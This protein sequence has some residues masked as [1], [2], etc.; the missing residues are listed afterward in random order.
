MALDY[1]KKTSVDAERLSEEF[2]AFQNEEAEICPSDIVKE[3]INDFYGYDP[4]SKYSEMYPDD[5][6]R[7]MQEKSS[8]ELKYDEERL[9][10]ESVL[11]CWIIDNPKKAKIW[12]TLFLNS[13]TD[14][15]AQDV[16][17]FIKILGTDDIKE[18]NLLSDKY[19]NSFIRGA[20]VS[21]YHRCHDGVYYHWKRWIEEYEEYQEFKSK[22]PE[23]W[24]KF[25]WSI[26]AEDVMTAIG[27]EGYGCK[28]DKIADGNYCCDLGTYH[29]N[30]ILNK[31]ISDNQSLW[32]EILLNYKAEEKDE[33]TYLIQAWLDNFEKDNDF[34]VWKIKNPELWRERKQWDDYR[35]SQEMTNLNMHYIENSLFSLFW[36]KE[37]KNSWD[38]WK[39][40]NKKYWE[41]CFEMHKILR[42][43]IYVESKWLTHLCRNS[44]LCP[45]P[46]PR[47]GDN[48]IEMHKLF[49][50]KH[51]K[52]LNE[53]SEKK[54]F[55]DTHC[56]EKEMNFYYEQ[57]RLYNEESPQ[58]YAD[59]KLGEYW[60]ETHKRQWRLWKHKFVWKKYYGNQVHYK[61]CDYFEVWKR[62]HKRK[63]NLWVE[64]EF[65]TYKEMV[66]SVDIWYSWL[67]DKDNAAYFENWAINNIE[68]W[69]GKKDFV[70]HF[71]RS[72]MCDS[73]GIMIKDYYGWRNEKTK[74]WD[75]WKDIIEEGLC[76]ELFKKTDISRA[77]VPEF[78]LKLKIEELKYLALCG[79]AIFH[80]HL[81]IIEHNEK[82]GYINE[83]GNIVIDIQYDRV[84]DFKRGIAAVKIEKYVAEE[85]IKETGDWYEIKYGGKWGI[86]DING[87]YLRYP[88]YDYLEFANDDII[89]FG[90]EGKLDL[91]KRYFIG[92]KW[93]LMNYEM[94]IIIPAKYSYLTLF[95]NGLIRA[96][97]EDESNCPKWGLMTT[98]GKVISPFK[99]SYIYDSSSIY[100]LANI[101]SI[102]KEIN[103][104]DYPQWD[105]FGGEWGYIDNTGNE[106]APFEPAYN[107]ADFRIQH[108]M[109]IGNEENEYDDDDY[110]DYDDYDDDYDD[111]C[112]ATS[113]DSRSFS[114]YS[115]S[116]AQDEMGYSDDDIDDIFDGDPNAY[117]NI[118]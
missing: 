97:V 4:Y 102:Y 110:D 49:I 75:Y 8:E 9:E 96:K 39:R 33:D 54:H 89:L 98:D 84:T 3:D 71:E 83:E 55:V 51:Y 67:S 7:M 108:P 50:E 94:E 81:A 21:P 118:D 31:W 58:M 86:I 22:A 93:G 74:E 48:E 73:F 105:Y 91:D 66:K 76:I 64:K 26:N 52:G 62:I 57:R 14:T 106:V 37:N 40:K 41:E 19:C 20:I 78:E 56:S 42:W 112:T 100:M 111:Y 116:Y 117:W 6:K 29:A 47:L 10:N 23:E 12:Y 24:Q 90:K 11:K 46:R 92:S 60:I 82:F 34:E 109:I 103:E 70:R 18:R 113:E 69:R 17:S 43:C 1:N 53:N 28:R 59:R 115:G 30:D 77:Y 44:S 63:W 36:I 95:K 114:R 38:I 107:D 2:K 16:D 101:N 13:R 25:V 15:Y 61:A 80:N 5:W 45:R 79:K 27:Y 99:Y 104:G 85:Y 32:R 88:Q 35:L 72:S 65:P 68:D 87:K